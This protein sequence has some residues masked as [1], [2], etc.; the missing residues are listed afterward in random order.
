MARRR[1][2]SFFMPALEHPPILWFDDWH[3]GR[4]TLGGRLLFWAA[5]V[6][7][8]LLLGELTTLLLT[9]FSF[10]VCGLCCAW[11]FGWLYRPKLR[12]A[13]QIV[14]YPSAGEVFSYRVVVENIGRR[15]ARN[16]FV[17]ER[18]L[19]PDLRPVGESEP[20]A[21]LPPGESA[22]VTLRLKCLRRGAYELSRMQ[23]ASSLP[24]GLV[25]SGRVV[26][27]NDRLLVCPRIAL[28]EALDLPA[29]RNYQPGGIS[30]VSHVGE[31]TEFFGTRDWRQGDRIR[32]IH[33]PSTART[34]R[35]IAREFQEEYFI[36]LALVLDIQV[37]S[38]RDES[39]LERA[40]S[41]T[42]G[43]ASVLARKDYIVDIFA[44]GPQVYH[45]QAGRALAHFDNILE[46]LACLESGDEL[47][48]QG[49][50]TVLIPEAS[51]LSSVVFVMLDWEPSR[52]AVV[53]NLKRLGVAVRVI[54][55][56]P[57]KV[58]TDLS[59]E[60]VVDPQP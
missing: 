29:V 50:E 2:W 40:V 34:G 8:T 17:E 21:F 43:I 11:L 3:R 35:L 32:D 13:R 1:R 20:I 31:S 22:V 53:R 56:R 18:G 58:P 37:K 36:R 26:R 19:P 7:G 33:W 52:A 6:A 9:G 5:I 47:N 44:A 41:L 23:G 24:T 55:V 39:L 60:E 59:P 30:V 16:V 12:F 10:S 38:A 51:R 28:V 57:G 54:S 49:L 14:N 42:A 48:V 25:K 4:L 27:Q 46:I 15:P 45:L